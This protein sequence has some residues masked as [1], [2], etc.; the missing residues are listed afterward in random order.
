MQSV[1]LSDEVLSRDAEGGFYVEGEWA[2]TAT[3]GPLKHRQLEDVLIQMHGDVGPQ[4]I[5]EVVQEL[6][7]CDRCNEVWHRLVIR[8]WTTLPPV[9]LFWISNGRQPLV[10]RRF[11]GANKLQLQRILKREHRRCHADIALMF[12]VG[13]QQ[14]VSH[15]N[16][17]KG[18][19]H[20][21]SIYAIVDGPCCLEIL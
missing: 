17:N 1:T 7:M 14:Q 11:V 16:N 5:R 3:A 13:R 4:L 8:D 15:D 18:D 21:I 2:Q 12:L 20:L 10:F 9:P 6:R 19:S